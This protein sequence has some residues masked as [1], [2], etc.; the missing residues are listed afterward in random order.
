MHKIQDE[1]VLPFWSSM[2][3]QQ[4]FSVEANSIIYNTC[5]YLSITHKEQL[6][7]I[8]L[9]IQLSIVQESHIEKFA[10]H[11]RGLGYQQ[12]MYEW[13]ILRNTEY[14]LNI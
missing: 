7:I 8:L 3:E 11:T 14:T 9:K 5:Y 10:N 13:L 6:A 4:I 2:I 1:T 12:D